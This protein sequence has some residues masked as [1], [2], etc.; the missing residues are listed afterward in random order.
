MKWEYTI[1]CGAN[2][3]R[4]D[5][6]IATSKRQVRQWVRAQND[7]HCYTCDGSEPH[8]AVRRR[9]GPWEVAS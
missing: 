1:V 4:D 2:G 7:T 8:Y 9:V 5:L 6:D 3:Y